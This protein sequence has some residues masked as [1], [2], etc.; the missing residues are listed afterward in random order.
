MDLARVISLK[1]DDFVDKDQFPYAPQ[2]MQDALD[3]YQRVLEIAGDIA[4][5]YIAPRA[6]DVDRQGARLENGEVYYARGTRQALDRLARADLMGFTIPRGYGGINMPKT[7]YSMAIEI[8]SRADAALMNLFGLQEIADTINKFGSD[9]QKEKYLPRFTSGAVT[10]AMALTEPDAG[11]DLQSAMLRAE[12][13]KDGQ[14]RLNGVKRFITNGCADV[15][16]VL[17]RSE[18][19]STGGRGLSLFLYERDAHLKI[20]RI[21][22]KL[23][24]HGS[25]TCELQFDNAPAELLGRR[26]M[27]LV[28]YTQS[29]MNGARLGV[30]AQALGIAEAAFREA[31]SYARYRQQFK[32]PIRDFAAVF[33]MLTM[34]RV[35][36][37]AARSLLYETS[38]IVDIAEGL[39]A[40]L[41]MYPDKKD[42]LKEDLRRYAKYASLFTPLIKIYATEMANRVCYDALQVHAGVGYTKEFNVERLYRDARITNIYEGTTQLQ[43]VAAIGGLITGE[44]F[45]RLNDYQAGYDFRPVQEEFSL[46]KLLRSYLESAVAHVKDK[47]DAAYQEFHAARLVDMAQDTVIGYLLCID[48]LSSQ[49]KKNIAGIFLSR[50]KYRMQEKM[51]YILADDYQLL[52]QHNQ[53]L[54]LEG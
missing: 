1:E 24:I 30:A 49:R 15:V 36:I 42:E 39:E 43:V 16:L 41:E 2:D 6:R 17:A 40:R 48:A 28:R 4:G 7:V 11:S 34:M 31:D 19:G 52:E 9:Q 54:D 18:S 33:E 44:I 12:Q 37:E 14:W 5:E 51:N 27:G 38:R 3:N 13:D 23:G 46:A 8:I 26:K 22:E 20:R 47:K 53:V 35:E 10:G 45:S 21:E 29:L 25:P 32:R 50:A